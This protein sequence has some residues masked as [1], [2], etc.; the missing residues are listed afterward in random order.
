MPNDTTGPKSGSSI[1]VIATGTP[2]GALRCTT[3]AASSGSEIIPFRVSH[4]SAISAALSMLRQTWARSG[5]LRSR[6]WV[7]LSTTFQPS[8]SPAPSASASV[9]TGRAS[10][11]SMS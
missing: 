11:L 5:R 10:Q 9:E 8:S 3:K 2:G 6:S 1:E 7:A 4:A